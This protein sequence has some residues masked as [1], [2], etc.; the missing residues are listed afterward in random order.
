M[1]PNEAI[2]ELEDTY[3]KELTVKQTFKY[4]KFLAKFTPDDVSNMTMKAIED[5]KYLPRIAQL[6]DA[7][8]DLLILQPDRARKP[9]RDCPVCGG[10]GW[11]FVSVMCRVT[12]QEEKAV[13]RCGCKEDP[14][15]GG[16]F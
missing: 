1:T 5:C 16:V 4:Q 9:D 12:R 2:L 14:G 11:Q 10:T 3:D 6:N 8:K 7:R 13:E 15:P